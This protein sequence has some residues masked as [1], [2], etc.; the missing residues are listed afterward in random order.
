MLL[1][2]VHKDIARAVNAATV[3]PWYSTAVKLIKFG[4]DV[5]RH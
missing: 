1:A 2:W 3:I 5:F 4:T